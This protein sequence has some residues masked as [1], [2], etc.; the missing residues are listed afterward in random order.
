M[1]KPENVVVYNISA[2]DKIKMLKPED[3]DTLVP[4]AIFN[5]LVAGDEAPFYKVEAIE[6][7]AKGS[8]GVYTKQFFNSYVGVTK[9]RPI[10]GSKRGHEWISRGHS[11]FYTVGGKLVDNSD[12]ASGVVYLKIYI[13]PKGDEGDNEG[14]IRDAKAGIVHFSLVSAPESVTKRDPET[15]ADIRYFT[16]SKGWERNDAVEYGTGAMRQV[17]N[18]QGI[19]LDI[20]A[21]YALIDIGQIDK[22]TNVEGEPIQNGKLY[23]SALRRLASRANEEDRTVIGELISAIDKSTKG[24]KP[25]E[26][27]E[28]FEALKNLVANAKTNLGE[29]AEA[30][31]LKALLRNEADDANAAT[32]KVLNEK[33]GEKPLEALDSILAENSVNA[34]AVIENAVSTITPKTVKNTEGQDV[35]NPAFKYAFGQANGKKGK[36]L[37]DTIEALKK[38]PVMLALQANLADGNSPVYRSAGS[39][40][41]N[42]ST[43]GGDGIPTIKIGRRA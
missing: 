17:V 26:K 19:V 9:K 32:V 33:L 4:S 40:E 18:T 41:E 8:G 37:S 3:V 14:F 6:Y 20:D 7:P 11:D 28:L 16:S 42:Q 25:V 38:D 21:A 2:T 23:R 13:P 5:E 29:I 39:K 1:P 24:G 10:P 31:G 27:N 35:E 22:T 43:V 12:G 34:V 15:G 30:V 36:E